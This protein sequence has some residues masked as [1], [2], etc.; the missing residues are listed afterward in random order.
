MNTASSRPLRF[1]WGTFAVAAVMLVAIIALIT[2][3]AGDGA[4]PMRVPMGL[5]CLSMLGFFA[6]RWHS[7]RKQVFTGQIS[8]SEFRQ[9][10]RRHLL[11]PRLPYVIWL[12]AT[13][14]VLIGTVIVEAQMGL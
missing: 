3:L 12:T 11:G 6:F 9:D 1:G 5:F 2:F 7:L 8:P 10:P 14:A 4:R 13:V